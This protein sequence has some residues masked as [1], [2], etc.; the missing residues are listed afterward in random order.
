MKTAIL[1]DVHSNL[2]ALDACVSH[3]A[4]NGA[5]RFACLGDSVGY[6]PDPRDTVARLMSL[7]GLVAVRG[8]HDAALDA[9]PTS[10]MRPDIRHSLEWTRGQLTAPQR[11]F[12]AEL[13]Y[14][15]R[16]DA[17]LYVHASAQAPEGWEYVE[18]PEQATRCLA[19]A[20]RPLV[21][22]GHVHVPRVYYETPEGQMRELDPEPGV[23][24]PISRAMR[25]VVNVGSV[26]QPRDG[27]PAAC[28]CLYDSDARELRFF[29]VPYDHR[30]TARKLLA[31][32]LPAAFARRLA[33][34][35]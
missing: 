25:Y 11:R 29:R 8:N 12:L 16:D 10:A 5:G 18:T 31:A 24:I 1:S 7:P 23:A 27:I 28:Y 26:G 33:Q 3:A 15:A 21:F 14:V 9:P 35:R 22:I 34:G 20:D 19:A 6:G 17:A 30:S 32:G 2:E 13:P 4:A